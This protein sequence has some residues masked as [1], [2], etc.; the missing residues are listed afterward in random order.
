M[1]HRTGLTFETVEDDSAIP[2]T[3]KEIV[4]EYKEA[5]QI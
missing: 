5:H 4:D 3:A 2:S 1:A